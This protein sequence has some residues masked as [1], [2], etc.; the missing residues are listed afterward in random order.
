MSNLMMTVALA[1]KRKLQKFMYNEEGEVNIVT[2]V[3]LIG[4]AV[5]LALILKDRLI[6]LVNTLMDNIG[7]SANTAITRP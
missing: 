7:T 3:V 2:I 6:A 1:A 5:V 4:V